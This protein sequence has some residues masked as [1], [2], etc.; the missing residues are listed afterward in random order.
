MD[1]SIGLGDAT[2]EQMDQMGLM[3]QRG[4]LPPPEEKER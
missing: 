1:G 4:V 2:L 3:Q